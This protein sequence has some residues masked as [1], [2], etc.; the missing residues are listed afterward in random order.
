MARSQRRHLVKKEKLGPPGPAI[1]PVSSHDITPPLLKAAD[2]DD[3]CLGAPPPP[4]KRFSLRI[5]DDATIPGE[6][7]ARLRETY[8]AERIDPVL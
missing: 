3:P 2:T 6:Q 5:M 8:L 1:A 4:Q 7:A